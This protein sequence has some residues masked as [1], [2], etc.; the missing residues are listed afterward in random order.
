MKLWS[1]R[2]SAKFR[3]ISLYVFICV[4]PFLGAAVL[5]YQD[6]GPKALWNAM[7]FSDLLNSELIYYWLGSIPAAW[8]WII[9]LFFCYVLAP[10]FEPILNSLLRPLIVPLIGILGAVAGVL[11]GGL[12][13]AS[14]ASDGYLISTWG[15]KVIHGEVIPAWETWLFYSNW[16][17]SIVAG[18]ICA[19]L[20]SLFVPVINAVPTFSTKID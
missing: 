14:Y 15:S 11:G 18:F 12:L 7:H 3:L 6:I 19:V 9:F 13:M 4:G 17:P 20:S 10:L 5:R 8:T 16:S 2:P 1:S